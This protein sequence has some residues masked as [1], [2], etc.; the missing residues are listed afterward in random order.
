MG[1]FEF[2]SD[3]FDFV[4]EAAGEV[5]Q[6]GEVIEKVAERA[7]LGKLVSFGKALE[8]YAGPLAIAPTPVLQGGQKA[9]EAMRS[10]TGDDENGTESGTAFAKGSHDFN[11]Q[12]ELQR[13]LRPD[14]TWEGGPAPAAYERRVTQQEDRLSILRDADSEVALI[15]TRELDQL[16]EA[17][18]ILD[19]LHNR[20]AEYG[21]YTQT[22]GVIPVI[23]KYAQYDAEILAVSMALKEATSKMSEMHANANA[24]AEGVRSVLASYEG[25]TRGAVQQDSVGD[26]DPPR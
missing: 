10:A 26:F 6:A 24:N 21:E 14:S 7:G 11:E 1:L 20:L 3:V 15:I 2:T 9:I 4:T 5:K 12:A 13:K 8:K 17:R 23:G 16:N 22:L 19:N 18:R 25:V